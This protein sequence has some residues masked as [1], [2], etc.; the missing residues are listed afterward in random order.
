M[1]DEQLE[2][3]PLEFRLQFTLEQLKHL[4]FLRG[5]YSKGKFSPVL[6]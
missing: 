5:E 6:V 3:I 2:S 1:T 4:F